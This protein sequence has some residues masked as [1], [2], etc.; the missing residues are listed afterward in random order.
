[1]RFVVRKTVQMFC[2]VEADD[3]RAAITLAAKLPP[4]AWSGE[5]PP[6]FDIDFAATLKLRGGDEPP[7]KSPD[8]SDPRSDPAP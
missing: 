8:T 7:P 2:P 6:E 5:S 4:S 3:D 1:M